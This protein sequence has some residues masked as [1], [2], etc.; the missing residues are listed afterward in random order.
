MQSQGYTA[1]QAYFYFVNRTFQ[2]AL[3]QSRIPVNWEEVFN[4]FTTSLNKKAIVHAW[5]D[6]S[7]VAKAVA[8]GY[9][10]LNS[11]GWYLDHLDDLWQTYYNNDPRAGITDTTQQNLVL[12]GETCMWGETVDPSDIFNTIWPRAAAVAERLWSPANITDTKL[13][14]GRY[15]WFR[16]LLT[17][18]GIGAA[19]SNNAKARQPPNGPG[20]CYVQ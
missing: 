6:K 2:I 14:L 18:R 4:H 7:T 3:N 1:D 10:A 19:P 17:R 8:V 15:E 9:Q 20:G 11:E 12:G 16:C 13:A 5:K